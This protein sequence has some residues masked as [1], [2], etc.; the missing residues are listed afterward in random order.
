F[1]RIWIP[2]RRGEVRPGRLAQTYLLRARAA[3]FLGQKVV[4][5]VYGEVSQAPTDPVSRGPFC[6]YG[7]SAAARPPAMLAEV[8]WYAAD[9][10]LLDA[11]TQ[12]FAGTAEP[13]P[14]AFSPRIWHLEDGFQTSVP[15][16]LL[17]L[18]TGRENDPT[19][20]PPLADGVSQ[21]SQLTAA[22]SL[23]Y[24]QPAV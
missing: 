24:C 6:R 10:P 5:A 9:E 17:R 2:W 8:S 21:A 12:A 16:S 1:T 15:S 18:Y 3:A 22:I 19:A 23:A 11:L 14:S 4:I 20:L 7:R 13:V